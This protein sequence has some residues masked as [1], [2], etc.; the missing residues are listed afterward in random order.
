[1][2][3]IKWRT[4]LAVVIVIFITISSSGCT[5]GEGKIAVIRLNGIIAESGQ[6]GLLTT[7]G[8]S[9]K[10]VRDFLKNAEDDGSIKAV[11]LRVNSPGGSAAASQE[12]ASEVRRFKEVTGKPVVISMGDV[13]AYDNYRRN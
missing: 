9:P 1:M 4:L 13:A 11:V 3:V 7:G 8:I 12:I 6:L 5:A 10:Q 2:Q